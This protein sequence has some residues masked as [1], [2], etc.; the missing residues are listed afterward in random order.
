MIA[1][2]STTNR[3]NSLTLQMTKYYQSLLQ[4]K[5]IATQIIDLAALP[6]DFLFSALYDKAGKNESFNKFQKQIDETEKFIFIVPEYNGSYPGVLKGFLDGLRYPDTWQGKKIALVA[7][8]AGMQGGIQALSH[9]Q[10]IFSYLQ[11]NVLGFRVKMPHIYKHFKEGKFV[12]DIYPKEIQKQI[13]LFL[14]F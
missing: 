3:D 14:E 13:D 9:L 4:A 5:N 7:L 12:E 11:S 6:Q 8:S 1:L 2:I 10:D